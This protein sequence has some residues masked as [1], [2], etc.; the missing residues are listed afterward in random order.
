MKNDGDVTPVKQDPTPPPPARPTVPRQGT[1]PELTATRLYALVQGLEVAVWEADAQTWKFTFVSQHAERMLGYPVERWVS[2]PGFWFGLIHPDDRERA[3][4]LRKKVVEMN[5]DQEFECRAIAADGQELWL[6]NIIRVIQDGSGKAR[7]LYGVMM[8]ITERRRLEQRLYATQRLESLGQMA[9]SMAHDFNNLLGVILG[10]T[11]SLARGMTSES[12]QATEDVLR[13]REAVHAAKSLTDDLLVFGRQEPGDTAQA[14]LSRVLADTEAMMARTLGSEISLTARIATRPCLVLV[15]PPRLEQLLLNLTANARDALPS[16]GQVCVET[17]LVEVS[18]AMAAEYDSLQPGPHVLLHF[19]DNGRGMSEETAHRAFEPFFTTKPQDEASGL[20]LAVVYGIARNA[21]GDV[22]LQSVP[23][24]GSTVKVYL[25]LDRSDAAAVTPAPPD[26][27]GEGETILLVEDTD[28]L[29][30]LFE[31]TLSSQG[32]RVIACATAREALRVAED[33]GGPLPLLVTDVIMPGMTGPD[34][35]RKLEEIQH[36]EQTIF[37]SG[38]SDAILSQHGVDMHKVTLLQKPFE[39][40]H[41]LA[42]VR[43][44]LASRR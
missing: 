2:E 14:D 41:L 28:L 30:R 18:P 43:Q 39:T 21:G 8:D 6:R 38:Y 31:R 13:I 26:S 15:P 3:Q 35:A 5:Q 27:P 42:A 7:L 22:V 16:G 12:G 33:L 34:L 4:E 10:Y 9:G 1:P 37:M 40:D 23:G 32:Y 20:G 11:E 24:E 29:L 19:R 44:K 25:P 36:V 17:S